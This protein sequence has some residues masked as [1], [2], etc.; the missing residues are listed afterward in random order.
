MPCHCSC[1]HTGPPGPASGHTVG[2]VLSVA[3]LNRTAAVLPAHSPG[4][5][6]GLHVTCQDLAPGGPLYAGRSHP[7][8][9]WAGPHPAPIPTLVT[10]TSHLTC[11]NSRLLV[12]GHFSTGTG[13]HCPCHHSIHH[14]SSDPGHTSCLLPQSGLSHHPV[15]LLL[16]TSPGTFET[17]T[18]ELKSL[19]WA[20]RAISSGL[21]ELQTLPISP[22]PS[23]SSPQGLCTATASAQAVPPTTEH[24]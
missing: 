20:H 13:Q 17:P 19:L 21:S 3:P 22:A 12:P 6:W 4:T 2:S 10:G 9:S 15:S 11:P 5:S 24:G 23:L 18:I 7:L 1:R 8:W 14:Q 16:V